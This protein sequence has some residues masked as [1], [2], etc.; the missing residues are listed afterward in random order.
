M[1]MKNDKWCTKKQD[2]LIKYFWVSQT[3]VVIFK[4]IT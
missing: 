4:N 3:H 2:Q 1:E